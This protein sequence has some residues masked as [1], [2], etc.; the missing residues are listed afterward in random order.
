[1]SAYGAIAT[2]TPKEKVT[3]RSYPMPNGLCV[4]THPVYGQGSDPAI[5]DYFWKVFDAELAGGSTA[6]QAEQAEQ[7]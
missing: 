4:T 7:S 5:V 3:A 1:M 2:P 6:A